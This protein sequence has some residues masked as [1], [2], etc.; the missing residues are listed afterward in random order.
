MDGVLAAPLGV[1]REREDTGPEADDVVPLARREERAV[2]A[3][4][5][6]DEDPNQHPRRRERQQQHE[7]IATF[8]R[9]Y[10]ATI[11][12]MNG[13]TVVHICTTADRVLGNEY[14]A[15]IWR[16]ALDAV[17]TGLVPLIGFTQ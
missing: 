6:D 13:R 11:R 14:F 10:I 5:H 7:P 16:Q 8:L 1:R 17:A 12:A 4:V 2:P 3:V 9:K 15:T